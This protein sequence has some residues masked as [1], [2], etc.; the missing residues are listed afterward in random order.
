[1]Q[2]THGKNKKKARKPR[3]WIF[4]G[5][6]E[7]KSFY[8]T[9]RAIIN[10]LKR[11]NMLSWYDV[12]DIVDEQQRCVYSAGGEQDI[13]GAFFTKKE[14]RE[15]ETAHGWKD[16]PDE[17]CQLQAEKQEVLI[18]SWLEDIA[19]IKQQCVSK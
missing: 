10:K 17:P 9:R 12:L 15:I 5:W 7:L 3:F 8:G 6:E 18:N 13:S 19:W 14:W 1:M 2:T 16:E 11:L 4:W